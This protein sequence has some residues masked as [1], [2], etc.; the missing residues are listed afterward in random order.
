[1]F[2]HL[3]KLFAGKNADYGD[4]YVKFGKVMMAVFPDGLTLKDE[5]DWV[6]MGLFVQWV[7]KCLRVGNLT[8]C[9]GAGSEH[10]TLHNFESI[11]DT[12]NDMSVYAQIFRHYV[13]HDDWRENQGE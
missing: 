11:E 2:E 10:S 9:A 8:W 6:L 3:E 7:E 5:S 1:M 4:A 13:S 12:C